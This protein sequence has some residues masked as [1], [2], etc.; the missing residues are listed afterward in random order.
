MALVGSATYFCSDKK[1]P[2]LSRNNNLENSD[3]EDKEALN[4]ND[5]SV[6]DYLEKT[7]AELKLRNKA[8]KKIIRY[9]ENNP[10][11]INNKNRR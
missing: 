8:F 4:N 11:S 3:P 2:G 5:R 9:F 10:K 7:I 1:N 6:Y